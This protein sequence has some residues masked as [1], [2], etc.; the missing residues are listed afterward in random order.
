MYMY[1][2]Q[3]RAEAGISR[4]NNVADLALVDKAGEN[5]IQRIQ[6]DIKSNFIRALLLASIL[7]SLCLFLI[8]IM[9]RKI[10]EPEELAGFSGIPLAG[11]LGHYPDKSPLEMMKVQHSDFV[12]TL[13]KI[14]VRI[15]SK[16]N[17]GAKVLGVTSTIFGE[18]KTFIASNLALSYA[19]SGKNTLL[20]EMDNHR[21]GLLN[22]FNLRDQNPEHPGNRIFKGSIHTNLSLFVPDNHAF[23]PAEMPDPEKWENLM[24]TF[25]KEFDVIVVDTAPIGLTSDLN[26]IANHLDTILFIAREDHTPRKLLQQTLEQLAITGLSDKTLTIYNDSG[27]A[28]KISS[29]EYYL[30]KESKKGLARFIFQVRHKLA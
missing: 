12:Q 16:L 22:I 17:G 4:S 28:R 24:A 19:M 20:V 13:R 10:S 2:M 26:D 5:G 1:L 23:E 15:P 9:S 11:V 29:Y 14:R 21:Q 7:P 27:S 8:F 30:Q 3:K 18:G 6:P 25:S